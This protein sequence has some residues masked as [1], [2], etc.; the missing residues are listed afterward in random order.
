VLVTV[1]FTD[2]VDST[3]HASRLGDRGWREVLD[4]HDHVVARELA[5]FRGTKVN[6]TGDGV[7]ATFDGPARAVQCA[8]SLAEAM[9]AL[10][11][12]TR[13]GLHTGEVEMRGADI[14]GIAV[15]IAA[16]VMSHAGPS[17]IVVSRTVVD[18]VAGSGIEFADRGEHELKGVPG[19]WR[20][21]SV[22][23]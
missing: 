2:L 22:R 8:R 1:L 16:R 9:R 14:S 15:V 5:R 17:E 20:I 4:A 23:A 3:T 13:A 6:T 18:L 10:G 11:I 12:D 7:L 21:F 19:A